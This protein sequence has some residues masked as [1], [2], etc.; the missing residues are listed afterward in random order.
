MCEGSLNSTLEHEAVKIHMN[1][2][3]QSAERNT[4]LHKVCQHFRIL[5][6]KPYS[7]K[8]LYQ[9]MTSYQL[10]HPCEYFKFQDAV[11]CC[12]ASV[13]IMNQLHNYSGKH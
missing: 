2:K 1:E 5:L 12:A 6:Y 8:M 11:Q 13:P 4:I 3:L 7:V 9:H 10:L